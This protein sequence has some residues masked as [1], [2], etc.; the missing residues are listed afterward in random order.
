MAIVQVEKRQKLAG[1]IIEQVSFLMQ[2]RENLV[3]LRKQYADAG[4]DFTDSDFTGVSGLQ[5]LDAAAMG[6]VLSSVDALNDWLVS[7]NHDDNF[8]KARR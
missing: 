5:H 2:A 4:L 1:Q 6:N 7:T 3:A 8:Q